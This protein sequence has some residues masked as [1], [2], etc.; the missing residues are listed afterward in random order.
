[1]EQIRK[2]AF[3]CPHCRQ[4]LTY[5]RHQYICTSHHSYDRAKSGYVNFLPPSAPGAGHGDDRLMVRARRDFLERGYYRKLADAVC[6]VLQEYCGDLTSPLLL[7]AGCGEGYYTAL[8]AEAL[9]KPDI[10][11]N[12]KILAVD[13][14]RSAAELCA[15]RLPDAEVAVASVYDLPMAQNS[16]DVMINIFSPLADTEYARVLKSGGVFLTVIPLEEHLFSLKAAVYDTP[17]R[18]QVKD[19]ALPGFAFLERRDV[20]Y[21]ITLTS[22]SDI[23]NLFAMTPYYYKTSARDQ[24]KLDALTTLTTEAAFGILVYRKCDTVSVPEKQ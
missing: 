1:M 5:D 8:A 12:P 22:L 3:L 4:P 19:T 6:G 11:A 2:S 23:K 20:R 18:N 21:P 13:I 14:S 24:A 15:R 17:Y 7:D 10:A 16:C 9:Q